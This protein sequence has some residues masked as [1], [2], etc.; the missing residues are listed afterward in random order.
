M[1]AYGCECTDCFAAETE[2]HRCVLLITAEAFGM[3]MP[4]REGVQQKDLKL[5]ELP[6]AT[7]LW[8]RLDEYERGYITHDQFWNKMQQNPDI[9]EKLGFLKLLQEEDG[10]SQIFSLL[11]PGQRHAIGFKKYEMPFWIKFFSGQDLAKQVAIL[12]NWKLFTKEV[13]GLPKWRKIVHRLQLENAALTVSAL[14]TA[15]Q[16]KQNC[17]PTSAECSCLILHAGCLHES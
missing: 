14:P 10:S 11:N 8:Q 6:V 1:S 17:A 12:K 16:T 7:S 13:A 5:I 3:T 15:K 4:H 2:A 9:A